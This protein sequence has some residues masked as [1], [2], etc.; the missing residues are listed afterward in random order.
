MVRNNNHNTF[1]SIDL[2]LATIAKGY[3]SPNPAV[4]AILTKNNQIISYGY[5]P[6]AGMYHAEKFAIINSKSNLQN[7][8][9][10]VTLEPCCHYGLTP[11]CTTAIINAKI[12]NVIIATPDPNPIVNNKGI[13][14]LLNA[15]INVVQGILQQEAQ[16]INREY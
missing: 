6:A 3:T 1:M 11:P 4:G 14:E 7:S 13:K 2:R 10:Y 8:T 15:N 9:L 16:F 12:K 5:H